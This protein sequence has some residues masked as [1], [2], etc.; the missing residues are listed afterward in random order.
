MCFKQFSFFIEYTVHKKHH[1]EVDNF[2]PF[3]SFFAL[4]IHNLIQKFLHFALMYFRKTFFSFLFLPSLFFEEVSKEAIKTVAQIELQ[5]GVQNH[6]I[7]SNERA[8]KSIRYHN[9]L[10]IPSAHSNY[11]S[12]VSS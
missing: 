11:F 10:R 9:F 8:K 7:P 12:V 6:S 3:S 1:Y 5:I 2:A 4:S